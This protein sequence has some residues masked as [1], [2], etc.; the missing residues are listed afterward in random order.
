MALR[1]HSLLGLLFLSASRGIADDSNV[2]Q[3]CGSLYLTLPLQ[4]YFPGSQGY[5][6]SI[7]S[8]TYIGTRL[9]PTC[10][11]CPKSTEDVSAIIKTLSNFDS[12]PFAIR[13]GGHNT[14]RGA[15]VHESPL[16]ITLIL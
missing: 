10:L 6:A 11:V 8:Y 3:A 2:I 14:N 5:E 16:S 7:S 9:R 13:S 12:V 4:V 15:C 1:K